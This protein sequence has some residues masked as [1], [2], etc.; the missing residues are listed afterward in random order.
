[1]K[2]KTQNHTLHNKHLDANGD[3]KIVPRI[4]YFT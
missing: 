4:K 1:M 3:K 2:A